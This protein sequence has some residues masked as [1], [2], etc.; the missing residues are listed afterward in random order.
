MSYVY[1]D[2]NATTPL[3]DEVLEAMIPVLKDNFGNPNS[4]HKWGSEAAQ[5]VEKARD[6]VAELIGAKSRQVYFNSGATEGCN[7]VLRAIFPSICGVRRHVV[8]SA[9]EHDAVNAPAQWLTRHGFELSVLKPRDRRGLISAADLT[10]VVRPDTGL[11]CIIGA[12]NEFGTIQPIEEL[13]QVCRSAGAMLFVDGAQMAGKCPVDVETWGVDF[14]TLSAHKMY[15][16][17]GVGALYVRRRPDAVEEAAL[18]LGG[19]QEHALRSGTLNVPGIVGFG[20]AARLAIRELSKEV[21][22]LT[23]LRVQLWSELVGKI[24]DLE[25]NGDPDSRLPGNLNITFPSVDA[26]SVIAALPEFGLSTGSA[27]HAD[28]VTPSA[29][30]LALG[31]SEREAFASLRIGMGRSTTATQVALLAERIAV[32]VRRAQNAVLEI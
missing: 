30:L 15:G 27:C 20:A 17:K 29:A 8:I 6:Q 16:P 26:N 13:A 5:L 10:A 3:A 12:H 32:A 4:R 1:F 11:V 24:P 23:Q 22:R 25:L 31:L 7:T 14:F 2:H 9:M 28:S 21:Y 18:M 19:G